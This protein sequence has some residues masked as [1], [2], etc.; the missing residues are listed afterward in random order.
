MLRLGES[1]T[2]RWSLRGFYSVAMGSYG[3][4]AITCP[5]YNQDDILIRCPIFQI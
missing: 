3:I 1:I 2:D 5:E 4:A